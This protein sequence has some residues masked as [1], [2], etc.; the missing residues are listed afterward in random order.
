[1]LVR[2]DP[3]MGDW[4]QT[5]R[6][7][8]EISGLLEE[9]NINFQGGIESN[10]LDNPLSWNIPI[11]LMTGICSVKRKYYQQSGSIPLI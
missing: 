1:V 2:E 3:E 7:D 11:A 9:N 6:V 10:F 4:I 8:T 5:V